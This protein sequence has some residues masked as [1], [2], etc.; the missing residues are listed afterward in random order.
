MMLF[1]LDDS[2]EW[3]MKIW[4]LEYKI[5]PEKNGKISISNLSDSDDTNV[6]QFKTEPSLKF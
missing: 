6:F 5:V 1:P 3:P 4:W 2:R